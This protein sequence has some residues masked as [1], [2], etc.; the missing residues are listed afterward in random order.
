MSGL[1]AYFLEVSTRAL[2]KIA[3]KASLDVKNPKM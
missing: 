3:T 1:D 2:P